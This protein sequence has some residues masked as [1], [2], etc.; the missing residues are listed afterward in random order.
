MADELE[1]IAVI[2]MAGRFPGADDVE[3]LWQ[4]LSAGRESIRFLSE[5][6]L[7]AAGVPRS[8]LDDPAYV[9]AVAEAAQLDMFDAALF[10]MTA[11][12]ARTSDPQLRLF[13]ETAH[14][15]VENAGYDPGSLTDVGVFGAAGTNRYVDLYL[16]PEPGAATGITGLA[17]GTWNNLGSLATMVS[18]KLDFTGPAMSVQTACSSSLVAIHQAVAA[19]RN[20]ECELALAGGVEVELPLTHGHRWAMD[21]PFSRDGHC[22]PF[23]AAAS[24]TIFG[25][26]VGVVVLKKLAQ[27][28]ADGDAVRAVVR[29]TAVNNDG[30]RKVGFTAPGVTGQTNVVLEAMMMAGADVNHVG[31]VEA[32]ATGTMLGDPIEVAALLAAYR[33]LGHPADDTV[34]LS[35]VK[36][37]VGHLGHAAGVTSFIR[38]VLSLERE[39]I[40]PTINVSAVNPKLDLDGSPFYLPS[41]AVPW[42]RRA[43]QPRLAAVSSL[44][45]GGTNAHAVLQEAPVRVAEPAATRPRLLVWSA[46]T[47]AARETYQERIR[48]HLADHGERTFTATVSTL[49][50]GRRAYPHRAALVAES[51]AEAVTGLTAA[52]GNAVVRGAGKRRELAFLFPG[53]GAQYAGMAQDLYQQEPRFAEAL[54]ETLHLFSAAG[55]DVAEA[56]RTGD[57]AQ[58]AST[59]VAQPLLFAVEY[60]LA[61]LWRSWGVVPHRLLGHSI[62]ELT[63]AAV[64]EVVSL[65]DAVTLVAVRARAMNR[66]PAGGMLAVAAGADELT[67]LLSAEV[68]L[69]AVNGPRQSVLA[70]PHDALAGLA[71]TLRERGLRSRPIRTSHAFHTEAMRKAADEFRSAFGAVALRAPRIPIVSAATGTT[72]TAHQATD[73]TFWADQLVEPVLFGPALEHLL[74]Q[75]PQVLVEV[76]PGQTLTSLSRSHHALAAGGHAAVASLPS[77]PRPGEDQIALLHSLATVWTDGHDV[78]WHAVGHGQPVVRTPLPVYPYQRERFWADPPAAPAAAGPTSPAA[79]APP[80]STRAHS[81]AAP[82]TADPTEEQLTADTPV[83]ESPFSVPCWVHVPRRA[84]ASH[85][86]AP[87]ALLLAEEDRARDLTVALQ[88]AG[89]RMVPVPADPGSG[90]AERSFHLPVRRRGEL[91]DLLRDVA[92]AGRQPLM[93]VHAW[94]L[95]GAAADRA[96][97]AA[98]QRPFRELHEVARLVSRV[99]GLADGARIVV[100]TRQAVDISGAEVV[101]PEHALLPP[102]ARTIAEEDQRLTV[103]LIDLGARVTDDDLA[104]ELADQD[105]SPVVALRGDLRWVPAER[106]LDVV[107]GASPAVRRNGVY[108]I[109]GGGGGLGIEVARGLARTGQQPVLALVG[110]SGSVPD[111]VLDELGAL[112]ATVEVH[113]CDVTDATA[114][115]RLVDEVTDR[116]GPVNG[117]LHLAGRIGSGTVQFTGAADSEA[118][119]A[120]KMAGALSLE[121]VFAGRPRLDFFVCFSSRAALEGQVGGADYAAANAYLDTFVRD[122]PLVADRLLSISWPAWQGVGMAAGGMLLSAGRAPARRWQTMLSAEND[123]VTDEHRLGSVPVVPGTRHLDLVVEAFRAEILDGAEEPV[124]LNDVVFQRMLELTSPRRVEVAFNPEGES[125]A[126]AVSSAPLTTSSPTDVQTHVRGRVAAWRPEPDTTARRRVDLAE[127]RA[128]LSEHRP[129]PPFGSDRQ[130]FTLGP[131]WRTYHQ[132]QAD[133]AGDS[134]LLVLALPEDYQHEARRH[135]V[136][137]TLMDAATTSV[138]DLDKDDIH[139]PFMY[140]SVVVHG[141]LPGRILSHIRRR[142]DAPTNSIMAD[143]DV[144]DEDGT[145][146]VEVRGFTMRRAT[147]PAA[148]VSPRRVDEAAE[149]VGIPP[150]VGVDLLMDLLTGRTPRQVA[151]RRFRGGRPEPS[152][153]DPLTTAAREEA[154]ATRPV[155]APRTAVPATGRRGPSTPAPAVPAPM[156]ERTPAA[157]PTPA[158]AVVEPAPSPSEFADQVRELWTA[159]TGVADLSDD[160]DFFALGG[161]SLIAVELM[162]QVR[163]RF[164][165]DLSVGAIFDYPTLGSFTE[166]LRRLG[167]G[168]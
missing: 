74:A 117:V 166:E 150:E 63:A 98:L 32:H 80:E 68:E 41:E 16:R 86:T 147:D 27:A 30:A 118:T 156:P 154:R 71:D 97:L 1:P 106:G 58:L 38:A 111:D 62:G 141:R 81:E 94:G 88:R 60:A 134:Q 164:G 76:G 105:G 125:W 138:R 127:L 20:G 2:G 124:A 36:A 163:D 52:D 22:R 142:P 84:D 135:A 59:T 165:V 132:A 90:S 37:N 35:S 140:R 109:T 112:G 17:V 99:S 144:L 44:G 26:G 136:H 73:P 123:P 143:L 159:A 50:H 121:R 83:D 146:L 157:E 137:P 4:N 148:L 139:V 43:D 82:T 24:G 162:S 79:E 42:P 5:D 48:A 107:P 10:G 78:D 12:E 13:L 55:T 120:P 101:R 95:S 61:Q 56:W 104:A 113:A 7:L 149:S 19:I 69:A 23:D 15:A 110:R 91:A 130:A 8:S 131:R 14:A 18:Y 72:M 57:D 46:A 116:R 51:A 167:A 145:V 28:L 29:A 96:D 152:P 108:L 119:F 34:A 65:S 39:R 160:Q 133:P 70:G 126:F 153:A 115:G 47:A 40:A 151:V 77:R 155:P 49:Q 129:L 54:D 92:A 6:E 11:R 67:D 33:R 128:R 85:D 158:P 9:R 100:L 3:Q 31:L 102:L 53:Q 114:L 45:I 75:G 64:A 122:T 66:M 25:S 93:L 103:R 21:G 161:D 87:H 89:I 168:R